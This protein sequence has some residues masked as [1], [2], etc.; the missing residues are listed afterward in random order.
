VYQLDELY[1]SIIVKKCGKPKWCTKL[2]TA[3]PNHAVAKQEIG[4]MGC[5][6]WVAS[7]HTIFALILNSYGRSASSLVVPTRRKPKWCTKLSTVP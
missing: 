6:N 4:F 2:P 5:F 3:L 1:V 7:P